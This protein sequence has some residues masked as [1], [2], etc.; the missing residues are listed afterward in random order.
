M[1]VIIHLTAVGLEPVADNEI[2]DVEQEIVNRNLVENLLREGYRRGFILDD[3]QRPE[4][5]VV[6]HA[7]GSHRL[8]ANA[9]LHLVG[10]QRRRVALMV[11][12]ERDEMLA[13]PLLRSKSHKLPAQNIEN[14]VAAAVL[15][16][17]YIIRWEIET[18]NFEH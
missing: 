17:A 8:V 2:V 9:E 6:Q 3:H 10:K 18:L 13:H 1:I 16:D 11:G 15:T 7:V 12:K 4:T 14:L 5:G